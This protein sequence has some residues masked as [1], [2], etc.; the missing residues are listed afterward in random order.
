MA[1]KW[2]LEIKMAEEADLKPNKWLLHS[3]TCIFR[4]ITRTVLSHPNKVGT[5]IVS[6]TDTQ[7]QFQY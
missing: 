6:E 1:T 5:I 3:F 7:W 4:L 2:I